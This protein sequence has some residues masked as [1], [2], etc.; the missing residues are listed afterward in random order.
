MLPFRRIRPRQIIA[1]WHRWRVSTHR[2]RFT[3]PLWI[4]E[5]RDDSAWYFVTVPDDE[6]DEITAI[7]E[8][9]RRGFGSVRV[10]VTVGP[11]TWRTSIFPSEETFVLPVKKAVRAKVGAGEGDALDVQLTLLLDL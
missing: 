5:A 6:A 2:Y 4:W 7:T 11:V 8:G 10:E 9:L 3:A 1:A